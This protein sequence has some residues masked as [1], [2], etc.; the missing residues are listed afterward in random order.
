MEVTSAVLESHIAGTY[1][2]MKLAV[3]ARLLRLAE[4]E[5]AADVSRAVAGL[6]GQATDDLDVAVRVV[7]QS[8]LDL[9]V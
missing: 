2:E 5:P 4:A 7:E 8:G 9:I 6:S 1:G 3:A